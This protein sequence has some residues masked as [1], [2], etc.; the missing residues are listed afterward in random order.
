MCTNWDSPDTAVF[1]IARSLV[2]RVATKTT[3][4]SGRE[5]SLRVETHEQWAQGPAFRSDSVIIRELHL[6]EVQRELSLGRNDFNWY[7]LHG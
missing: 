1:G 3:Q 6:V 4:H 2:D 7:W 5:D